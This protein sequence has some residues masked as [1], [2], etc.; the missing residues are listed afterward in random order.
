MAYRKRYY[1]VLWGRAQLSKKY[2]SLFY[3]AKAV[4]LA[5]KI[6]YDFST[7]EVP[8][9]RHFGFNV[10]L[11]GNLPPFGLPPLRAKKFDEKIKTYIA[12]HPRASVVNIGAGLDT[13]F[14]RVD[15]GTIQ[16]YDLDLPDVIEIRRQLLPEPDRTTYIAESLFDPI[17]CKD[18]KHT[19][20]GVFMVAGGVLPFFEESQVKQFFSM[21]A[22]N[23]P[24]GEIIF[25]VPSKLN[26][27]FRAWGDQFPPEQRDAMS[28]AWMEALKDWWT[29]A[30]Q[31]QKDKL[32]NMMASLKTP[33]KPKGKE[34]ADLEAW[35]NQLSAKEMGEIWRGFRVS[36]NRYFG[37]WTLE[38]AYE[39]TKW[40]SRITVIDQSPLF[41]DIPRDSSLSAEIRQFMDYSDKSGRLNIFQLRV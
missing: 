36:S 9:R 38:D 34:W 40:D 15:N 26:D 20:G 24:G 33:T 22:D 23:F 35:W 12:E 13:T 11:K 30:P 7:S 21:L 3:D 32:N 8:F 6:D 41:K 14:Y 29:K 28:A 27:D 5:E 1:F 2:S 25:D 4:E 10:S 16:W 37:K 19:E 39:I 17:W 31:D 18:I